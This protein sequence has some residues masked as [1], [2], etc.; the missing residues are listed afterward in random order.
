MFHVEHFGKKGNILYK[1]AII[2]YESF[3]IWSV[4]GGNRGAL[5]RN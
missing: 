5:N 1:K 2:S 3:G 4:I